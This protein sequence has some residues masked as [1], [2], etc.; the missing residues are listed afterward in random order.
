MY[1]TIT[2]VMRV[3]VYN[4][5]S[6]TSYC[7]VYYEYDAWKEDTEAAAVVS[8]PLFGA[9]RRRTDDVAS[10]WLAIHSSERELL[11]RLCGTF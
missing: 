4:V 6:G 10:R 11:S 5:W 3:W 7:L 8:S 2:Y 9:R 1:S